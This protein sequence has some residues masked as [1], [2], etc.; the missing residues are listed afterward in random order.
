MRKTRCS[1]QLYKK[2]SVAMQMMTTVKF[3][4]VLAN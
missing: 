3:S 1:A 2:C 4:Q